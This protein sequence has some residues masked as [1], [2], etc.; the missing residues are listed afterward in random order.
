MSFE[1]SFFDWADVTQILARP[2][3]SIPTH[4][5][6]ESLT[7]ARVLVTGAGGSVGNALVARLAAL[8]V[9]SIIALDHHEASLFRLGR[10]FPGA[11]LDLVLADIRNQDKVH[12]V[13]AE[14]RPRVVFHLAAYKHVPLGEAGVDELV[15]VNVFGTENVARAAAETGVEH[16]L[17]PSSDKAVNPPSAYGATKRIAETLLLAL[18]DETPS[19][20]IH[21]ARFV[22]I[23]GSAG[24]ASETFAR[25]ASTGAPLTLTDPLMTRYWM[26]MDEAI[27]LLIH[28]LGLPGGSLTTLD[29]GEPIPAQTVAER[30][31]QMASH[32]DTMPRFAVT[33]ARPGERLF[34]EL[35]SVSEAIE[36]IGEDPVWRIAGE[37]GV[38]RPGARAAGLTELRRLFDCGDQHSLHQRM[39]ELAHQLQ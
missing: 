32:S 17:Y 35:A 27:D 19:M 21:I 15:G 4:A 16:F 33:G 7:G 6:I 14:N 13:L 29:T 36:R 1:A 34:E 5:G 38:E 25:Q 28:G 10:D 8:P 11:P 12:R 9:Q 37:E 2:L 18:D 23:L 24:S 31:Y 3:R 30:I 26:A 22:N 20:A 39:M